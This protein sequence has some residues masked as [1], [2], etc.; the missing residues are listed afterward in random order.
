[1]LR[2]MKLMKKPRPNRPKTIDGTPARFATA[3]RVIVARSADSARKKSRLR[4]GRPF[5][6]LK[7][8]HASVSPS[9]GVYSCR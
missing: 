3:L 2:P 8:L 5:D 7:R 9:A 4:P 1:M 6:A